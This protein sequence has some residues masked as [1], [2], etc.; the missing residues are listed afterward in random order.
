[1]CKSTWPQVLVCKLLGGPRE[2][3]R[4][5]QPNSSAEVDLTCHAWGR[6]ANPAM[7]PL[8]RCADGGLRFGGRGGAEPPQP[9]GSGGVAGA[10]RGGGAAPH[11]GRQSRLCDDIRGGPC[12]HARPSRPHLRKAGWQGAPLPTLR[13][14]HPCRSPALA[15]H[16][17][18]QCGCRRCWRLAGPHTTFAALVLT[19][20]SSE[21]LL[22]LL[23]PGCS[24]AA[25][26]PPAQRWPAAILK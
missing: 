15:A 19:L 1:M 8:L 2:L 14:S 9:G 21:E 5:R 6:G 23:P 11:G 7:Q 3:D 24:S 17:V 25:R 26:A 10:V 20:K 13:R 12:H 22:L 18:R 16:L 4:L